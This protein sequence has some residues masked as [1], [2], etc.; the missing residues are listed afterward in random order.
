MRNT[1][2]Y[3]LSRRSSQNCTSHSWSLPAAYP[4]PLQ[5]T[6]HGTCNHGDRRTASSSRRR[7]RI[8][9]RGRCRRRP[10]CRPVSPQC[11]AATGTH[12]SWSPPPTL[13]LRAAALGQRRQPACRPLCGQRKTPTHRLPWL[14]CCRQR[15]PL[16]D[17]KRNTGTA[18]IRRPP[19]CR[20][21]RHR[22]RVRRP[23][24]YCCRSAGN[25]VCRVCC[26][27][28]HQWLCLRQRPPF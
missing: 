11:S 25:N 18:T 16:G 5:Q 23:D 2:K 4:P 1:W 9:S 7:C 20:N 19:T 3:R 22:R 13:Y 21:K 14:R 24:F 28:H 26:E 6:L 15:S 8:R 17:R 27:S 10:R 12:H